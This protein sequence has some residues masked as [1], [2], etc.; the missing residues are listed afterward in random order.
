MIGLGD[1]QDAR[2]NISPFVTRTPTVRSHTL[3]ER[4]GTN[5]YLKLELFQ[6]TGSFKP[7][8]AFNRML[9]LTAEERRQGSSLSAAE[10][11]LKESH[12]QAAC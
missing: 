12:T 1:V 2:A 10:T 7:R 5:V 4:L 11:S 8:G 6:K 9:Q 3:S